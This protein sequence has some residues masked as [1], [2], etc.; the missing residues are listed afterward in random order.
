MLDIGD[1]VEW[2][3]VAGMER[4]IVLATDD[5]KFEFIVEGVGRHSW[6]RLDAVGTIY[7]V[8][9]DEDLFMPKP[10]EVWGGMFIKSVEVLIEDVGKGIVTHSYFGSLIKHDLETFMRTY[11]RITPAAS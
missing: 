1:V 5:F 8:V 10:G 11:K 7:K 4:G 6:D 9:T 2:K 3:S